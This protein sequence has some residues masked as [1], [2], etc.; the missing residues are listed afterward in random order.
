MYFE[1]PPPPVVP[2]R[3]SLPIDETAPVVCLNPLFTVPTIDVLASFVKK[4]RDTLDFGIDFTAWLKANGD[5][6]LKAV[7]WD[8]VVQNGYVAPPVVDDQ[9]FPGSEAWVIIGPGNA[10]DKYLIDCTASI[11]ATQ[12]RVGGDAVQTL[13]R[14]IVRRILITVYAG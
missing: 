4:A 5:T 6:E 11:A 1:R 12:A 14:T 3:V 7:Q 2:R 10:G 13:E 8:P 9:F